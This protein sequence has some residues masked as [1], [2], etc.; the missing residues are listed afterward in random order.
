[1][2]GF[3]MLRGNVPRMRMVGALIS[4]AFG[5]G[6]GGGEG[7]KKTELNKLLMA[8]GLAVFGR[9]LVPSMKYRSAF[10][11]EEGKLLLSHLAGRLKVCLVGGIDSLSA[12]RSALG[13]GFSSVAV[14]RP[15]LRD[16][17]WLVGLMNEDANEEFHVEEDSDG[18]LVA[19]VKEIKWFCGRLC[20]RCGE[21]EVRKDD[22]A[23]ITWCHVCYGAISIVGSAMAERRLRA[24]EWPLL[25][26][27]LSH[28]G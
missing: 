24:G 14:A 11:K 12:M 28:P 18:R 17:N 25:Y 15:M 22:G 27:P 5:G 26:P 20:D 21:R 23:G 10:F 1:M 9:L 8:F 16:P 2:N 19:T 3:Y 6:G 4:K 13:D 7:N